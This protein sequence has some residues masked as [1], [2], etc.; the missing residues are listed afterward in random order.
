[1]TARSEAGYDHA[2]LRESNGMLCLGVSGLSYRRKGCSGAA[3]RQDP[4]LAIF[5]A[6]HHFEGHRIQHPDAPTLVNS[7]QPPK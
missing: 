7:S 1:M 4:G 6:P 5:G 2:V 3:S